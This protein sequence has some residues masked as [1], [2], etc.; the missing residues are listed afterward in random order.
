MIFKTVVASLFVLLFMN[1]CKENVQPENVEKK[2]NNSELSDNNISKQIYTDKDDQKI[3]VSY[4][5]KNDTASFMMNGERVELKSERSASGFSYA[6]DQYVLVGKGDKIEITKNGEDVFTRFI[7]ISEVDRYFVRNDYKDADLH[8]VKLT[9]QEELNKIFAVGAVMGKNGTP[10]EIDFSK[11]YA[12]GL[13]GKT[14]NDGSE[15]DI[16]SIMKND[17][18]ITITVFVLNKDSG[19][20]QS[21]LSRPS[22]I[23]LIDKKYQGEI[24][25]DHFYDHL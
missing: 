9:T 11:Y 12:V 25:V 19:K 1:A 23:L 20:K 22:K 3:E 15:L 24:K 2:M 18:L 10:T 6:N 17:N 7:K 13:I 14:N 8:F 16:R 21:Y 4:D 5:S